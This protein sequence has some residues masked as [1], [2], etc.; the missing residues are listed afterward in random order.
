MSEARINPG[1][2]RYAG[3]WARL[4]AI[5]ID[6]IIA[7]VLLALATNVIVPGAVGNDPTPHETTT[8]GVIT[9]VL[10]TLWFNYL[11][12][13]EWLWG[14]T[15][16]KL[17]VGLEVASVDGRVLTW[18]RAVVRNLLLVVDAI[19][20]W[21]LI[22]SSAR[23]QRLGD[24][25]THT[26]VLSSA[27]GGARRDRSLPAPPP[28]ASDPPPPGVLPPPQATAPPPPTSGA[29]APAGSGLPTPTPLPPPTDRPSEPGKGGAARTWGPARVALGIL[30]LLVITVVEVGVVS[31]FD[32]GLNSLAA[33]LVTQAILAITLVGVA[34]AFTAD[35]GR[36]I[37][38]P[39]ALGLRRPL[40][41][42]YKVA[43]GA[44]LGYVVI[45]VA[46]STLVHPEQRDITTDLG[47]GHGVFGAVAAGLLIVVAAPISEEIFFRGFIFG[48]LRKRLPFVGAALIAA[49]IFGLFHYTGAGSIAVVPQLAFLGFALCWVY[50]ETGSIYPTMA[51]HALNNA[52]A[53]ILL[54]S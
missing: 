3:L 44:Y 36:G 40:R 10:L 34:F 54:V 7:W 23:G 16:G 41:S 35:K 22:P 24:R 27:R 37:A 31:I 13:S 17:A 39:S 19:A 46:Y 47:F 51:I 32:P 14:R 52:V 2:P 4:A 49:A 12:L 25:L 21:F 43:A 45:A 9:L 1:E 5:A 42:P 53:F 6:L 18:N 50:E 38:P 48:G 20:G 15:L 11:V 30:S 26:V 8:L 29:P 28:P 33:R